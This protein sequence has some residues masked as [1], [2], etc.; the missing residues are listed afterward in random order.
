MARHT[1]VGKALLLLAC[2]TPAVTAQ[3]P[4]LPAAPPAESGLFGRF[5]P[6]G[7]YSYEA[8]NAVGR[9]E[10]LHSFQLFTPY[11]TPSEDAV[12]FL[13]TRALTL[14]EYATFGA[15]VGLGGRFLD[16]S[17]ARTWGG[18]AFY[19]YT[20]TGPANFHQV[21]AGFESLGD[22]IDFRANVYVPIGGT[23]RQIGTAFAPGNPFFQDHYLMVNGGTR[24]NTYQQA[25]TGFDSEVGYRLLALQ[26]LEVRSFA[27]FYHYQGGN[28]KDIWGPSLRLEARIND[29]LTTGVTVRND[30]AFGTT[31]NFNVAIAF[32]RM[33]GRRRDDGPAAP[34]TAADRLG[35]PVVRT[36]TVLVQEQKDVVRVDGDR[37]IDPLTGLPY[38]FLHVAEGNSSG[39]F[40]NPYS[41]LAQAFNDPR[42][43][44]GN[45][46]VYDRT[47]GVFTGNVALAANTRLL[48]S[49]PVQVLPTTNAGLVRLPFSGTSPGLTSLPT[50][51]GTITV[52]NDAVV[53]GFNINPLADRSGVTTPVGATVRN[54]TVDSNVF[55]G[56]ANG[57][58]LLDVSGLVRISNNRFSGHDGDGALVQV[59]NNG[60]AQV[61]FVNNAVAG[62]GN[63]GL[64]LQVNTLA[65]NAQV[66]AT[67][68]G[69][70]VDGSGNNGYAVSPN[71]GSLTLRAQDNVATN[72]TGDGFLLTSQVSG[73]PTV[74]GT[75]VNNTFNANGGNGL[76][77]DISGTG[78]ALG[79]FRVNDNTF[80]NNTVDGVLVTS[81][82][83][84][85]QA[86][87]DLNRNTATADNLNLTQI[88]GSTLGV[89]NFPTVGARNSFSS[90]N[91]TGT[92][93]N[94]PVLP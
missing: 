91:T 26:E 13:D 48:S 6:R 25:L 86:F 29:T 15:N 4:T 42:F 32:P 47:T 67:F 92:I 51:N 85:N 36:Q 52:A 80:T 64:E 9:Q 87:V 77:L 94:V 5:V 43:R 20:D 60:P 44:A 68:S 81:A 72:N 33:S 2:L 17:G 1:G 79:I 74:R 8:G 83:N 14:E 10:G 37:A 23:R 78:A 28:I 22:D 18:Y 12:L 50:I 41:T 21:S 71:G 45:V 70:R 75:F 16:P 54:V 31:V 69:N 53:S 56:G 73:S 59:Q 11:T 93:T 57:V 27:G 76:N 30:T 62:V 40:E 88:G 3:N 84:S 35:D 49:G 89:V 38:F 65:G 63:N 39:T 90:V 19:D 66:A 7:T 58:D 61:S 24:T 55:R 82:N 46:V 34:L